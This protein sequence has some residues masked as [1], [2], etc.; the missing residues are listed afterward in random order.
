MLF[1][2]F[3][4]LI[5]NIVCFLVRL[6]ISKKIA[7]HL[8]QTTVKNGFYNTLQ[9]AINFWFCFG[10][11]SQVIKVKNEMN[12]FLLSL[13]CFK[14]HLCTKLFSMFHLKCIKFQRNIDEFIHTFY[15]DDSFNKYI[16]QKI[17]E[18][19]VHKIK[20]LWKMLK[21]KIFHLRLRIFTIFMH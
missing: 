5:K 19:D 16:Q 12:I 1:K 20:F 18:I 6:L 10:N 4:N 3:V 2:L 9:N 17:I 7:E 13:K 11:K 15:D 21:N 8:Q 14:L